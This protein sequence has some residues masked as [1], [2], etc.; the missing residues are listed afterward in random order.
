M[1][2]PS[3]SAARNGEVPYRRRYVR[4]S[5]DVPVSFEREGTDGPKEGRSSDLGGGGIRLATSDD[6]P[7]GAV[8]LLRFTLPAAE[9]EIVAPVTNAPADIRTGSA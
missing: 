9:Q 1:N 6:L 2:E 4:V 3:E 5:L 8:L 7:L